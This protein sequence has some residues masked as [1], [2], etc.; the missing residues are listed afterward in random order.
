MKV[1]LLQDADFFRFLEASAGKLAARDLKRVDEA[2]LKKSI[3]FLEEFN[4]GGKGGGYEKKGVFAD[5]SA[6]DH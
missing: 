5:E 3:H 2:A 6:R 1:A 4:S